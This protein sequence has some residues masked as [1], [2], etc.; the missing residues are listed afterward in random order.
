MNSHFLHVFLLA[1]YPFLFLFSV[2]IEQMRLADVAGPLLL[3]LLAAGMF[4]LVLR[5]V[6]TRKEKAALL[7]SFW[8]FHFYNYGAFKML[9]SFILG[10]E[11]A[12]TAAP[13]LWLLSWLASS[14]WLIRTAIDLNRLH[15]FLNIAGTALS[16]LPALTIVIG[17]IVFAGMPSE[18]PP[19]LPGIEHPA[20]ISE[21]P[22]IYYIIL[23]GYARQD[24]LQKLYSFDNSHFMGF[25]EQ[26]GFYVASQSCANYCQSYLSISSSLNMM[27]LHEVA[28]KF[29]RTNSVRPLMQLIENN[30]VAATL[31]KAGY[32]TI[33]MP[34][35]YTGTELRDFDQ[36][37]G[38]RYFSREFMDIFVQSTALAAL[39]SEFFNFPELQ[40]DS[41]RSNISGN[42]AGLAELKLPDGPA[43]VFAHILCPHPPFV[44]GRSGKKTFNDSF[45]HNDGSH[46]V[47][48]KKR[49]RQEYAEQLAYLNGMVERTISNLLAKPRKCI[50]ILQ[51]DHG[52]GSQL[53]WENPGNTSMFERMGILNAIYY[54]DGDYSGLHPQT[55]PVNTFRRIFARL[56]KADLAPLEEKSYFSTMSNRFKLIDVTAQLL[57]RDSGQN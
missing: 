6:F 18:N 45:S 26:Q 5:P 55:T 20:S 51:S 38:N 32:T 12:G 53:D 40:L 24:V 11:P 37:L 36:Y 17:L 43:F 27:H 54:P 47:G 44:F 30:R 52:P 13:V 48:D 23:D 14:I 1:A 7:T 49:Y 4:L 50:I 25:L 31:K 56:L 39:K 29:I 8:L 41:Y 34:S 33:A 28:E 15:R 3:S 9:S 19:P 42:I 2:N 22:D 21:L 57:K 46:W 16:S 10:A 35:G